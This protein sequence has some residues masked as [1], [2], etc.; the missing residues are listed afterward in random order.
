M[1]KT[2]R[3]LIIL[4]STDSRV[5]ARTELLSKISALFYLSKRDELGVWKRFA[6]T[7]SAPTSKQ[8][9]SKIEHPKYVKI[10]ED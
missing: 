7:L 1:K 4:E 8:R 10:T 6:A 3:V 5:Q 2:I 9:F